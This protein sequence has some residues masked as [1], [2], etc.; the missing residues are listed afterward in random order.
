MFT[1]L[2]LNRSSCLRLGLNFA[3]E[4]S[5]DDQVTCKTNLG[6]VFTFVIEPFFKNVEYFLVSVCATKF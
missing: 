2:Q 5:S 1:Y 4:K 3:Y 6:A